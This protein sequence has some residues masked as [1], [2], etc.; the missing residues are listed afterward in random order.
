MY[1]CRGPKFYYTLRCITNI[2]SVKL[3]LFNLNSGIYLLAHKYLYRVTIPPMI[4]GVFF[5]K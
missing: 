1:L 4:H 5:S 2:M 3:S